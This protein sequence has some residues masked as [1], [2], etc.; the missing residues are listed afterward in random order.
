MSKLANGKG[1]LVRQAHQ[2]QQLGVDTSKK[3]DQRLLDS[4]LSDYPG[5]ESKLN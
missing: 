3:I 1:N 2:M 5:L 4:A